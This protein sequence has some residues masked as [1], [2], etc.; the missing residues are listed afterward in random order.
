MRQQLERQV[1]LGKLPNK[2]VYVEEPGDQGELIHKPPVSDS[3]KTP[4][5]PG[6]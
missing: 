6:P 2:G 3:F 4:I 5:R 1:E